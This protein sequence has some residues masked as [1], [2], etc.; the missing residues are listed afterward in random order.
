MTKSPKQVLSSNKELI[1]NIWIFVVFV[2]VFFFPALFRGASV[3]DVDLRL[4]QTPIKWFLFK[5]QNSGFFPL[6]TQS[7]GCGYPIHAYGEGGLLY[8]LNWPVYTFLP[9]P[10]AHDVTLMIHLVIAGVGL[11]F[12]GRNYHKSSIGS[13]ISAVVFV[14]SGYTCI[15]LGHL[16]SIQVCAWMPWAFLALDMNRYSLRPT[17]TIWLGLC[18]ALMLLTGRTQ[19]A[20]Y[21]WVGLAIQTAVYSIRPQRSFRF[22]AVLLCGTFLG[23]TLSAAQIL[24]TLEFVALS[25]RSGG[26]TYEA[27][28]LGNVS[29][30]QLLWIVA[31]LWQKEHAYG[32]SSESI[33]YIGMVAG[34]LLIVSLKQV[35]RKFYPVWWVMLIFPLLLSM[36]NNFPLNEFI[37]QLP[38]FSYFRCPARWLCI[39]IFAAS[40]LA[41]YGAECL[42][43]YVKNRRYR[44]FLGILLVLVIFGDL[45]Y[46]VRPAVSFLDRNAQEAVPQALPIISRGGRYLSINTVPIFMLELEYRKIPSNRYAEY[47]SKREMLNDNLGMCYGLSSVEFYAGLHLRWTGRALSKITQESLSCMNCEFVISPEPIPEFGLKEIWKNPF[48]HI[49]RNEA[50]KPRARLSASLIPNG[51]CAFISKGNIQGSAQVHKD[52]THQKITIDVKAA[53]SGYLI[54]ADTFYPGWRV[55][56]NGRKED[57]LRVNGWM[58][59]VKISAG[60]SAVTFIYRPFSFYIG[61][62]ISFIGILLA[63]AIVIWCRLKRENFCKDQA[64]NNL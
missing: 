38:F 52:K 13:L 46:F 32:V 35:R 26:M 25:N 28:V 29:W 42:L 64:L 50:V 34:F 37:S 20:F 17:S 1:L 58:R 15:H 27:Q 49:Y 39:S 54:L 47:F 4:V 63:L 5:A 62:G 55:S 41:G 14:F 40:M 36:G 44:I 53:K 23:L 10:I 22:A 59:A 9:L 6:W 12:L 57:I 33:G 21:V 30:S 31:P 2:A 45:C 18:I 11:L 16:N 24:P 7:I 56:V 8:P 61:L 60:R 43:E 3:Y 19:I 48:F 51:D